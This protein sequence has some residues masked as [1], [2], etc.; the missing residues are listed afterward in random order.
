MMKRLLF[1]GG[2][3]FFGKLAI[4]QLLSSKQYSISILTR[5][6][7]VCNFNSRYVSFIKADRSDVT[8]LSAALKNQYFDIVVDNIAY[9][10]NDV[11]II[12]DVLAGKIE[13]YLLCST[14]SVYPRI[15]PKEWQE[16]EA[17]LDFLPEQRPYANGK[18]E[19]ESQLLGYSDVPY[20]IYRPTVVQGENDPT[21]RVQ[22]FVDRISRQIHFYVSVTPSTPSQTI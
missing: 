9:N 13:H 12:L 17:V 21:C 6:N 1:I 20:T 8:S 18:R 5:G 19:A 15:G 16:H 10:G 7:T 14:G 11:K 4:E 3:S 2:T 22:Y